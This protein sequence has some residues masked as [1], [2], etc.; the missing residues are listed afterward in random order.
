MSGIPRNALRGGRNGGYEDPDLVPVMNLVCVLIPL[1]LWVTTWFTFGQITVTRGSGGG[2]PG[3][4]DEETKLRLVA[5]LT[6]NSITLMADRRISADVLPEDSATGT[7]GRVDIPHLRLGLEEIRQ[8]AR[9]VYQLLRKPE[10]AFVLVCSPDPPSIDD[11][12]F[13]HDRL[14]KSAMR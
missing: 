11:A 10:V 8:R 6:S 9:D 2:K 5:V 1:M 4:T 13:F 14:A 3:T 12:L 7:K